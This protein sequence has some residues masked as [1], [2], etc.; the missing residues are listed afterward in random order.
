MNAAAAQVHPH[1]AS[2]GQAAVHAQPG[3]VAAIAPRLPS[4]GAAGA[5]GAAA[6]VAPQRSG[7]V[8]MLLLALGMTGWLGFQSAQLLLERQQLATAQAALDPQVQG[9]AK[10]RAA[11][12][13]VATATAKLAAEGNPNARAIVDQLRQRGITINAPAALAKPP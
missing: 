6:S 2:H 1:V 5:S 12:D 9:A 3:G 10:V 8:P 11:L 7:F 13:A 4:G